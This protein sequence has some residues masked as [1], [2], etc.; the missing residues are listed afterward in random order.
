MDAWEH[1]EMGEWNVGVEKVG[2]WEIEFTTCIC[3]VWDNKMLGAG[4]SQGCGKVAQNVTFS[5][6]HGDLP[7][8]ELVG[9]TL[10][11]RPYILMTNNQ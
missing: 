8:R 5:G 7:L 3:N 2:K 4:T 1:G 10:C 6:R 9:A 11:G